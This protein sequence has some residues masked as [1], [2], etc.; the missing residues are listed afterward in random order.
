RPGGGSYAMSFDQ[1]LIRPIVVSSGVDERDYL[2]MSD[3]GNSL[4]EI[5]EI[6]FTRS[7][8]KRATFHS[9]TTL[10]IVAIAP[11]I[12]QTETGSQGRNCQTKA[13]RP[14]GNMHRLGRSSDEKKYS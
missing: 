5:I 10:A 2:G 11:H 6:S 3:A 7:S 14:T 12:I 1:S 4:L 8:G 13:A 9:I